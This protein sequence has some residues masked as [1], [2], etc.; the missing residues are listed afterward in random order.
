[1]CDM[2]TIDGFFKKNTG[3]ASVAECS[4]IFKRIGD[5]SSVGPSKPRGVNPV[6]KKRKVGRPRKYVSNP[7]VDER[8]AK[9]KL[10]GERSRSN[11]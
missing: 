6:S 11:W 10:C 8:P 1:M 2:A 9:K 3:T 7:D 5:A 4:P